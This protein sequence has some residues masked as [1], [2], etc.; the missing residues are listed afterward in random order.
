MPPLFFRQKGYGAFCYAVVIQPKGGNYNGHG[1]QS[2]TQQK[3]PM[4]DP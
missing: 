3:K 1:N 4:V 2:R